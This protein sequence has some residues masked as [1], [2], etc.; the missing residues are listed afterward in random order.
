MKKLFTT[1]TFAAISLCSFAQNGGKISGKIKDGGNQVVIDAAAIS[2]LNAKDSSL[3]K[4]SVTDKEGGFSF[5]NVKDGNYLVMATSVGHTK[6]YSKPVSIAEGSA[7]ETGVLQLLP[8]SKNM[9]EVVVTAKKQFVERK[10][11]KT[12]INPDALISNTGTTAMEVLEKAPGV[13]V[14]KDGNISLKG[15]Q[16]VIVMLDGKPSYM[17][18]A[19][20]AN[21]LRGLPSSTI[22]NIELMTNPSAKYDASGNSGIINIRTKKNKQRGFNGSLST[23]YGQGVYPKT[24]NSINLNYKVGKVN[25]F[26]TLSAN[27][28]ENTNHLD[29]NRIY[30]NDDKTVRA[31]FDQ[32]T[33]TKRRNQNYN[34]KIGMDFYASKKT[35]LGFVYQGYT[36]PG[37]EDGS[38]TSF[39]KSPVGVIDSIVTA[40]RQEKSTWKSNSLNFNV[41]HTFDSTGR[42]LTADLD[43]VRYKSGRVQDFENGVFNPDYTSKYNDRLMGD[44]P[45]DIKIYSAKA[46]YVHPLKK[47]LKM[48]AGLKFSYVT[49]DN[50]ANYFNVINDVKY[51]DYKKTNHFEY[52]ENINAAYVNFSKNIKKWG[53]Q[54]GLRL[55]NTNYEGLQSGN[56]TKPDSSF[57]R[58]YTNVF[59]T[60][61][62]SYEA[63]SK[64]N[65]G[66]SFGRRINR[67]D[68][69]DL[70]PFLFF[71][72]KYTYEEGN[73]FLKPMYSNV[74]ELSHTYNQFLTTTLNYSHTTDLFNETFRQSNQPDDSISTIVSRGNYGIVNNLSLAVNAQVKVAKWYTAMLYGEARYLQTKGDLNGDVLDIES[75][76]LAFNV[77]NQFSFKKG[78]GAELSGFYRT[79]VTEGQMTIKALSQID[80]AVKKDVLKGK[81]SLR[82]SVRDI[83]G[84]MKVHGGMNFQN[85]IVAFQQVRDSRVVTLGFNYRFG[86]PIKGLKN[87]R[88][89]GA[90]SEQDRIKN[91]N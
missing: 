35:T 77:N 88:S 16:G 19:D 51:V 46:D 13:S 89:G 47:G 54:L 56:P 5:E 64:N 52:Q 20:L 69:E 63:D 67:P 42:E 50:A 44:L 70:N 76:N 26:S 10:I 65:F 68:Y 6:V 73:P 36:T 45:A 1:L 40:M 79:K 81:G 8:A 14:D 4:T 61:Y 11:D 33:I 34:G 83:F 31:I 53:F 12:I 24:N 62:I 7:A 82:L 15:K 30:G 55:E 2:L 91:A 66:F 39:L 41:R 18:G 59:P 75:K 49:T 22:E 38:S 9:A 58:S 32:K 84:P 72:D 3:V 90:G 78:W 29:I 86:K 71:I 80:A 48:E 74:F 28:R 37:T 87:R 27:Y 85:T 23:S 21:Y 60:T 17:S 57:K 43:Y 25:I